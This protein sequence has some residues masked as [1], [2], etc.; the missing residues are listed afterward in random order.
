MRRLRNEFG[1]LDD[2]AILDEL[3]GSYH[4]R[5]RLEIDCS[6]L[7]STNSDLD[8]RLHDLE[9]TVRQLEKELRAV[10]KNRDN[11]QRRYR[12]E[13]AKN[14]GP[15]TT[16][17]IVERVVYHEDRTAIEEL[18]QKCNEL[19]ERLWKH[20]NQEDQLRSRLD[21]LAELEAR[22]SDWKR[23]F[24]GVVM[25]AKSGKVLPDLELRLIDSRAYFEQRADPAGFAER[26]HLKG[27]HLVKELPYLD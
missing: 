23:Q 16:P 18:R 3:I 5:E 11:L 24:H 22:D 20:Q 1:D 19:K 21:R 17:E 6:R 14:K 26:H 9:D 8:Q 10:R 27:P 15:E 13:C 4:D 7:Q 2:G 12:S 25:R